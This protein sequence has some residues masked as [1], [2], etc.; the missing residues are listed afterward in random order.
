MT[1]T[2][3]DLQKWAESDQ[4]YLTMEQAA[5]LLGSDRNDISVMAASQ[6]GREALGFR[7]IRIGS[8]TKIPRIPFLRY[9]GYEGTIKG[10][11]A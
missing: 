6:E 9:L 1:A 8:R 2:A 3:M 4:L 7:V 11:S 10:A 5:S